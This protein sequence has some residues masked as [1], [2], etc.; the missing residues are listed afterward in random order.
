MSL[1]KEREHRG[2]LVLRPAGRPG[3]TCTGSVPRT[4]GHQGIHTPRL[5][6][7]S[8]LQKGG[9]AGAGE[10]STG[11]RGQA[12]PQQQVHWEGLRGHQQTAVAAAGVSTQAPAS[13]PA[14]WMAFVP[15]TQSLAQDPSLKPPL[16][17]LCT[18]L[19]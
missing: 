10:P 18:Q 9:T 8:H 2:G 7:G 4:G 6:A 17:I 16:P 14:D 12:L 19:K 1:Q 5:Q 3:P 11:R 15:E 13:G